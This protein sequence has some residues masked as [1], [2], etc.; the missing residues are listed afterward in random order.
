MTSDVDITVE[1]MVRDFLYKHTPDA[2]FLGE[3][4]ADQYTFGEDAQRKNKLRH[5]L[6]KHLASHVQRIRMLGTSAIDLAWTAQG[7]LDACIM[8]GNKPWDTSAGVLI[9]REAG[10]RVLDLDGSDHSNGSSATIAVTPTLEHD[11]MSIVR[12]ALSDITPTD[13]TGNTSLS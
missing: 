1:K 10:A 5:R 8:L 4:N 2:G 3:R 13:Q 9:A 11:F 7:R 12:T 6:T